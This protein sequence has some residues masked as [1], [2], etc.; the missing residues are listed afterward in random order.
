M[1][2]NKKAKRASSVPHDQSAS[3]SP[4]AACTAAPDIT[5]KVYPLDVGTRSS[6]VAFLSSAKFDSTQHLPFA[7]AQFVRWGPVGCAVVR[8]F[9][10]H[11][12][13]KAER[14]PKCCVDDNTKSKVVVGAAAKGSP[15]QL[16]RV[17]ARWFIPADSYPH[18]HLL[19]HHNWEECHTCYHAKKGDAAFKGARISCSKCPR[20]FHR[21]RKCL[22][23]EPSEVPS[24]GVKGWRCS[25]CIRA[26]SHH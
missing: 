13:D 6:A 18:A 2:P 10:L 15:Q 20:T 1:H 24:K 16:Y 8:D 26:S 17:P 23:C 4:P 19:Q 25:Y 21:I 9:E 22:M 11:T 7:N 12:D 5:G 14:I 3:S